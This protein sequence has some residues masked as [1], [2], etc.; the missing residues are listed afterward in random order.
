M[1]VLD[2]LTFPFPDFTGRYTLRVPDGQLLGLIGPS[3]GGKTTLLDGIAGFLTPSQ[4][5]LRWQGLSLLGVPPGKRPIAMIFQDFNLFP[6]LTIAQNVGLALNPDLR[7]TDLHRRQIRDALDAVELGGFDQRLP[8]T[9][10]GGQRQRAAIARALVGDRKLLLLDEAFSG[11]DPGLR[12]AMLGLINQLRKT[13]G[14]TVILSI[15]TPDDLRDL[16]DAIAFV[17]DGEVQFNGTPDAFF[18]D[19]A[20][21]A[22]AH[23]LGRPG[24]P[25]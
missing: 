16:A 10:S 23:Y 15:H 4:G 21:A 19:R 3:G 25:A 7:W 6:H 2:A 13:R 1:L 17:A 9:L 11:L 24:N 20:N 5:E 18:A 12:K 8:A 14:L 22:I